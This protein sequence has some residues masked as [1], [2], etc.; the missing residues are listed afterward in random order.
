MNGPLSIC[1]EIQPPHKAVSRL[2]VSKGVAGIF[3]NYFLC[4]IIIQDTDAWP[5]AL[6]LNCREFSIQMEPSS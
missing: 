6:V 3:N 4:I 1:S 5:S 2:F